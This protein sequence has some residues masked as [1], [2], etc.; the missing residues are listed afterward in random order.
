MIFDFYVHEDMGFDNIANKLNE[1][2]FK[3]QKGDLWVKASI[4]DIIS[5]EVYIGKVRWKYRKTVKTIED[6]QVKKTNPRSKV[7]DYLLFDGIHPAIISQELFDLAQAKRGKNVPI[8]KNMSINNPFA[9]IFYCAKCGKAMKMRPQNGKNKPRLECSEM[10]HC[11]NGSALFDEIL[12]RVCEALEGCISDF[13]VKLDNNNLDEKELW[14]V[15]VNL[16]GHTHQ[17]T[18]FYHDDP[19]MYH[20]GV[21]S[22][23]GYP[24]SLDQVLADVRAEMKKCEDMLNSEESV[25]A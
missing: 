6:Q 16:Y 7:S 17:T 18:N 5:N 11:K 4:Q 8:R 14:Q 2:G 21:D 9:G 24:V 1:L 25:N 22:H 15:V 13:E 12:E 20:V 23:D 10:K 19:W 3:P